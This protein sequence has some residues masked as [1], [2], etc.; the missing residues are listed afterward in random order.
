MINKALEEGHIDFLP[1]QK[2]SNKS[3]GEWIELKY[4]QFHNEEFDKYLHNGWLNDYDHLIDTKPK[5]TKKESLLFARELILNC[6]DIGKVN[7][8]EEILEK[9]NLR[10][11]IIDN[12]YDQDKKLKKIVYIR[13]KKQKFISK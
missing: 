1:V 6:L 9:E 10:K 13:R 12:L 11:D 3:I 8:I 4:R 2:I 7:Q 5:I